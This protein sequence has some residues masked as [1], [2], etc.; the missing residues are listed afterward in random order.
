MLS[1]ASAIEQSELADESAPDPAAASIAREEADLLDRTLE[2][3]P[4]SYREPLV[5][6]YREQQSVA[7]VAEQLDLS[8]DAVK[9]RL[10]RGRRMLRS[11][12]AAL[13][14]RGLSTRR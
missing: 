9:Q 3:L 13:V 14:Q 10:A 8:P 4:Q 6:F 1:R 7:R 2:T 11:E 5:L 12:V